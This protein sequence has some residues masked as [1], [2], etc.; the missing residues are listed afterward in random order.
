MNSLDHGFGELRKRFPLLSQLAFARNNNRRGI[1]ELLTEIR[2]FGEAEFFLP[3]YARGGSSTAAWTRRFS[4]AAMLS[5]YPPVA[6]NLTSDSKPHFFSSRCVKR[7]GEPPKLPT[8]M[9]LPLRSA[10]LLNFRHGN[11]G[12]REGVEQPH[13]DDR[14]GALDARSDGSG[15]R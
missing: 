15:P 14:I 9:N 2:Q 10:G 12:K 6:K 7:V 13:H 1:L 8:P 4:K 3:M 11:H 5:I